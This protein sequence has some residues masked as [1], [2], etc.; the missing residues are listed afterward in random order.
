MK[1]KSIL[2]CWIV[3]LSLS[4]CGTVDVTSYELRQPLDASQEEDISRLTLWLPETTHTFRRIQVTA[5]F[6]VD[7][8]QQ[9]VFSVS[10][11]YLQ[12]VL[13]E[14]GMI[15][16]SADMTLLD[17][18]EV[19]VHTARHHNRIWVLVF[20]D[21]LLEMSHGDRQHY[22][23]GLTKSLIEGTPAFQEQTNFTSTRVMVGQQVLGTFEV[24]HA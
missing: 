21:A 18:T 23:S 3:M 4:A 8:R 11:L 6:S 12:T 14:A 5:G 9:Q 17:V 24:F 1:W 13:Q 20:N 2:L 22:L 7:S 10:E 16:P 15:R 19:D